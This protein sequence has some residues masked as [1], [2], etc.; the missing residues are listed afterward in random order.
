MCENADELCGLEAI[1]SDWIKGLISNLS[2]RISIQALYVFGSRASGEHLTWSD[3][4]VC[5][6][7]QDFRPLRPWKRMELVLSCWEGER[8]LEPVCLTPEEFERTNF[9]LIRQIRQSGLLLYP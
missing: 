9:T 1:R 6:V 7:S 4:D 8:A 3:Y 5:V 2:D